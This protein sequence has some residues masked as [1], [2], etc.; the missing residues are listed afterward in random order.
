MPNEDDITSL[1]GPVEEI[2]GKLMLRI[3]LDVAGDRL[4]EASRGISEIDGEFL[5]VVIPHW[6]A[7]DL[8]LTAGSL[9]SVDN[10]NGKFNIHP[11]SSDSIQ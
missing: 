10:R 9:V 4:R 3:P 1:Q 5:C 8:R 11:M 2:N 6:L 7:D